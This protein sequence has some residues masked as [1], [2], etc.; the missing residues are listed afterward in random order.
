M[1]LPRCGWIASARHMVRDRTSRRAVPVALVLIAGPLALSG[2]AAIATSQNTGTPPFTTGHELRFTE[3]NADRFRPWTDTLPAY[4]VGPGDRLKLKYFITRDMDEELTVSPDG[5]IAPRAIGQI[6]VE[7]STL[8]GVEEY[9]RKASRKELVD[10]K[11]VVSLEAAAGPRVYVGGMVKQPGMIKVESSGI[12]VLQGVVMAGGFTE[13][14]RTGQVALIRRGPDNLP[15]LRLI[16]VREMIETGFSDG[17]VPLQ[18]GDII[19][20]PRSSIAE[21]NLWIDQFINRVV[22]FQRSFSYTI[23]NYTQNGG[24]TSLVP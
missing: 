12:S 13:E 8:T 15:M 24:T 18:S 20:V 2:C 19:F 1:V 21:V 11:V 10:Q 16:D 14:A 7:G 23:G 3:V 22:P 4:R 6:R 5:T 9:V 17:D